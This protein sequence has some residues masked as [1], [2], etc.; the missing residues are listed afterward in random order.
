MTTPTEPDPIPDPPK[1]AIEPSSGAGGESLEHTRMTLG[2]HLD[3]LRVRLIRSVIAIVVVFAATWLDH[4][5][6]G[7]WMLWPYYQAR[8]NLEEFLVDH[9]KQRVESNAD[10]DWSDYFK[11][12]D[13]KGPDDLVDRRR[14]PET[15]R[16]DGAG[17]GFFF[18]LRFCF[19]F[20]LFISGPFIL[21]QMWKFVA[22]GLYR[23][24]KKVVHHYFPLS[25]G[26]FIAGILFGFFLIVPNGLY[27]LAKMSVA[28][29]MYWESLDTYRTFLTSMT[30]AV[31]AVFQLPVVMLVLTRLGIVQAKQY[32]RYRAHTILGALV[33]SALITPPDVVT[34][35]LMAGPVFVLYEIGHLMALVAERRAKTA[36][37]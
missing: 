13:P 8:D 34:Q 10:E 17:I 32:R 5:Q 28:Q 16:G 27:F 14:I 4:K 18:Y 20:S 21:Y 25:I 24:E 29:I 35:M 3:E 9:F 15:P 6:V 33:M 30:L 19:Y 23:H 37:S 2:E 1:Q 36:S 26:L 11:T 31:G 12:A 7:D 22:A